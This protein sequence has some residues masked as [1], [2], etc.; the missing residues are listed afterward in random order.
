MMLLYL[1]SCHMQLESVQKGGVALILFKGQITNV[2]MVSGTSARAM[3]PLTYRGSLTDV[4]G[5]VVKYG[6]HIAAF[7][8]F[9]RAKG[10]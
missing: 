5:S 8:I 4:K 10:T 7:S 9:Q 1:Y 6:L 3:T 2:I